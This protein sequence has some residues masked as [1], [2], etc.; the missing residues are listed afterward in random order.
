MKNCFLDNFITYFLAWFFAKYHNRI[1][2]TSELITPCCDNL[3]ERW[4]SLAT[5]PMTPVLGPLL[6]NKAC[7]SGRWSLAGIGLH[8]G[9]RTDK[10]GAQ[11]TARY[12]RLGK[13]PPATSHGSNSLISQPRRKSPFFADSPRVERLYSREP[14]CSVISSLE[15]SNYIVTPD[16]W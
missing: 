7:H 2:K 8:R 1:L 5:G 15:F 6:A 9:E 12:D 4:S 13:R 11:F 3:S 10:A 14:M 16:L